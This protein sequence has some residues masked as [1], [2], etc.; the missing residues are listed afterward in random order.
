MKLLAQSLFQLGI[1]MQ[2]DLDRYLFLDTRFQFRTSPC[3]AEG[4]RISWVSWED[5]PP[6]SKGGT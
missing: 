2:H 3:T 5:R 6:F 1:V 4:V